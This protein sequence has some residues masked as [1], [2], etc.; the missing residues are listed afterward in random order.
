M[1]WEG[2]IDDFI[3]LGFLPQALRIELGFSLLRKP[4]TLWFMGTLVFTKYGSQEDDMVLVQPRV[5]AELIF[6]MPLGDC[7]KLRLMA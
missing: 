4:R 5:Y 3:A 1:N 7:R 6:T 2:L